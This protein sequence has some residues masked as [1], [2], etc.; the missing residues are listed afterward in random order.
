MA[1]EHI[2][3]RKIARELQEWIYLGIEDGMVRSA[4][5]YTRLMAEGRT[6]EAENML[7]RAADMPFRALARVEAFEAQYGTEYIEQCLELYGD[8]TLAELKA[9]I[10]DKQPFALERAKEIIDPKID[11]AKIADNITATVSSNA[12]DWIFPI[13]VTHKE[14]CEVEAAKVKSVETKKD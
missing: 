5:D 9:A 1:I 10:V 11:N 7:K 4:Q 14:V 13:P 2:K 12:Q 3:M 8:V 6:T